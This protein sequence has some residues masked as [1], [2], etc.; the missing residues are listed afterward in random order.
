L[1]KVSKLVSI[2]CCVLRVEWMCLILL[3][4]TGW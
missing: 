2:L 3:P 1:N 4:Y